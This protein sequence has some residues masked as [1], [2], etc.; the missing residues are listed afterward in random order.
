MA[1]IDKLKFKQLA[2]SLNHQNAG[3][4]KVSYL[5]IAYAAE[6]ASGSLSREII[7]GYFGQFTFES[8]MNINGSII[9]PMDWLKRFELK[10]GDG[11]KDVPVTMVL[12]GARKDLELEFDGCRL[13]WDRFR[14][15][16]DMI[17]PDFHIHV[18]EHTDSELIAIRKAEYSE[19]TLS[20]GEGVLIERK[21]RKQRE[22]P[23]GVDPNAD[24][25]GEGEEGGT[26][27]PLNG[28]HIAAAA[29]PDE[30]H[31]WWQH[32]ETGEQ[33]NGK[34]CDMPAGCVE[35]DPPAGGKSEREQLAQANG[36]SDVAEFERGAADKI[37]EALAAPPGK[38]T[39]GRS[40]RVKHRDR[41]NAK[42]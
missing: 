18:I 37:A 36:A 16:G 12:K 13:Y 29:K 35:I 31:I 38:V 26:T 39:D 27:T 24:P 17:L 4:E 28:S 11:F 14:F 7:N 19:V 8:W 30:T 2:L 3:E 22:L 23:F 20:M 21:A 41:Q 15:I 10:H 5:S 9:T 34:R 6:D 1:T 25:D 33:S 40:E 42:H 32:G